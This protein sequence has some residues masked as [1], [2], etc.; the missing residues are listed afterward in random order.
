MCSTRSDY[1][2]T[3]EQIRV[4]PFV[5]KMIGLRSCNASTIDVDDHYDNSA[6]ANCNK[7]VHD[8]TE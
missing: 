7:E 3:L 8:L 5:I 4:A 2:N 6:V 1:N